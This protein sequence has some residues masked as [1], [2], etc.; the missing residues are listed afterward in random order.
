MAGGT[1][2]SE[3]KRAGPTI[4][5][6]NAPGRGRSSREIPRLAAAGVAIT[7]HAGRSELIT[8]GVLELLSGVGRIEQMRRV[9]ARQLHGMAA[10]DLASSATI[11]IAIA[12]ILWLAVSRHVGFSSA[13]AGA[14]A[15]VLLGQRLAFASQSAG[16]L[17]ESAMFINDFLAFTAQAPGPLPHE[18]VPEAV[19]AGPFGPIQAEGVTFSYPGSDRVTL[20][21]VSLCIEPGEVVALVGANGSGKTTL[22]KLLA[23]LYLPS[24]GRVCWDGRDTREVDRREL[25]SHAAI[26]F[27]DFIRYALSAGDNIALGRHERAS[28]PP[29][30]RIGAAGG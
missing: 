9:S 18:Q 5:E 27:Q 20:R 29:G 16:M 3:G 12:G 8:I 14:A 13:A 15:L 17:Q 11:A 6:L 30:G 23:G 2:T 24:E 28:R 7:W 26:V 4:Y 25:L 22:A 19:K 21:G 10:A 1:R